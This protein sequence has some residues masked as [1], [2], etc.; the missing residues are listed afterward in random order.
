MS[1]LNERIEK[2]IPML[3]E[4]SRFLDDAILIDDDDGEGEKEVI[5]FKSDEY[6]V[7]V[8]EDDK[9]QFWEST[10]KGGEE[11]DAHI[12]YWCGL[13]NDEPIM[14]RDI[15]V[16]GKVEPLMRLVVKDGW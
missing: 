14:E 12:R 4:G 10:Y 5:L 6:F 9:F 3:G 13:P 2:I 15:F 7:T 11:E 8:G 16:A 1:N